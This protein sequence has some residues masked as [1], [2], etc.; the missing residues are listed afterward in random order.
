MRSVV[1]A[2]VVALLVAIGAFVLTETAAGH[3]AHA[4]VA[5]DEDVPAEQLDA[6]RQTI[7]DA[8]PGAL[9]R[10][11]DDPLLAEGEI[12]LFVPPEDSRV[13]VYATSG[14]AAVAQE[15]ATLIANDM[16]SD[17]IA[18]RR[19]TVE[20][21]TVELRAALERHEIDLTATQT[22]VDDAIR[23]E[24]TATRRVQEVSRVNGDDTALRAEL[25]ITIEGVRTAAA[26][27]DLVVDEINR[28]NRQLRELET[29]RLLR[30]E[31]LFV[32]PAGDAENVSGTPRRNGV[33]VFAIALVTL[34]TALSVLY[35]GGRSA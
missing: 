17:A 19:G 30:S 35:V 8:L 24:A 33:E 11:A 29:E 1:A 27:R 15:L 12:E 20:V 5:L 3:R 13:E 34:L 25:D 2:S 32:V 31:A 10:R 4:V 26:G 7:V 9:E 21:E 16:W 22:A 28:V 6:A 23:E 18:K 14:S